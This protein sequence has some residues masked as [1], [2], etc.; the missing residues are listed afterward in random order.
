MRHSEND[1]KKEIYYVW[2]GA[3]IRFQLLLLIDHPSSVFSSH[4]PPLLSYTYRNDNSSAS[5]LQSEA[6][7]YVQVDRGL[8]FGKLL[9]YTHNSSK[10]K[11]NPHTYLHPRFREHLRGRVRKKCNTQWSQDS[12]TEGY[13]QDTTR[14]L[15]TQVTQ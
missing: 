11:K 13:L 4:A 5:N 3:P 14:P 1:R 15:H 6:Q 8:L 10:K 7:K 9:D 12:A 2:F